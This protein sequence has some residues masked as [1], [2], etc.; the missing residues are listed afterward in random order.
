MVFAVCFSKLLL[1]YL[2]LCYLPQV[3]AALAPAYESASRGRQ[4]GRVAGISA[5]YRNS[6]CHNKLLGGCLGSLPKTWQKE[7]LLVSYKP[8]ARIRT[9]GV[10]SISDSLSLGFSVRG[11]Y[12]LGVGT[13]SFSLSLSW[14][15][16][17]A[18]S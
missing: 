10:G 11:P 7:S 6:C 5:V 2:A 3:G 17:D 4:Y 14:F 9:L 16:A 1:C 15:D 12:Y 8:L 13:I 18:P